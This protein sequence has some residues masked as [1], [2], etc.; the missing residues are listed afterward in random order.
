MEAYRWY[1]Q[2]AANGDQEAARSVSALSQRLTPDQV[3]EAEARAK[4][5]KP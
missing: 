1:S 5:P 4:A 3:K 2:A